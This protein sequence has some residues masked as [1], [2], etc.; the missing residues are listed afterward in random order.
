M[1]MVVAI[2]GILS[3]GTLLLKSG[4]G[5]RYIGITYHLLRNA[6]Y[7]SYSRPE[8]IKNLHFNK[9]HTANSGAP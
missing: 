6:E 8:R 7:W 1:T 9:I 2:G 4:T 3:S 5:A